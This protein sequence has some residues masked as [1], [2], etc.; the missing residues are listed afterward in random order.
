MKKFK[1]ELTISEIGKF[2]FY[3]GL[4]IGFGY[5][6]ILNFLFHLLTKI[7]RAVS[8]IYRGIWSD[9][10]RSDQDFYYSVLIGFLSISL[11]FCFTTYLW[12]SKPNKLTRKETRSVRYAQANSLFIFGI[13]MLFLIR[14]F[15]IWIAFDFDEIYIDIKAEYGYL[16]FLLP[17]FILLF[18]WGN[19]AKVYRI[20]RF[21]IISLSI[22]ILFGLLLGTLT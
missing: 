19:I 11:A 10:L 5:S 6:I 9:P 20:R 16:T 7:N 17:T 2:R 15:T 21:F 14:L 3:S 18:N 1:S 22:I 12:M 4:V 13:I 8:I